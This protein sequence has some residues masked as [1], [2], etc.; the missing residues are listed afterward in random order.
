MINLPHPPKIVKK[1]GNKAIF[2]I[3][4][5]HPGYGVTIGNSL[6]RVLL[7]SLEGAAVTQMKIKG[8]SHEF[9]A[10][11]G[12]LEDVITIMLNL[13]Q[14]RFR[15][16]ATEP[17]KAVLK[18]KGEKEVKGSDFTIP[19]QVE[20]A[21]KNCLLA[22]LTSKSAELEME[23]QIEK[24]IGYSSRETRQKEKLEIGAIPVD[25]IFTPVKRV[26]YRIENM[27]VGERTDYD[28]LFLEIETDG[29]IT[30]EQALWQACE[31]LVKHFS[32]LTETLKPKIVSEIK[33]AKEEKPKAKKKAKQSK[34]ISSSSS[35]SLS[36]M[37]AQYEKKKKR[38]KTK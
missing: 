25:A 20:L 24:G 28:R 26:S 18:V 3:E 10:I 37:K 36:K 1:E 21:N 6:R 35:S 7:S 27:R 38:K 31:I 23:I 32:L 13:K 15:L 8:V 17:Q 16:F 30:P 12:V 14:L 11:P 5:L 22:T 29:I 34:R 33:P 9:S 19:A 2:E 4:A